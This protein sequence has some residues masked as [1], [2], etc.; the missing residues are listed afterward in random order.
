MS[1]V[2][3]V[4]GCVFFLTDSSI[5]L[6]FSNSSRD[7]S[8]GYVCRICAYFKRLVCVYYIKKDSG[9]VLSA[10]AS[11]DLVYRYACSV[12]PLAFEID[13]QLESIAY[14]TT[15]DKRAS[16]GGNNS[17]LYEVGTNLKVLGAG[18]TF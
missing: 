2:S 14:K 18:A 4:R 1:Y 10:A 9:W 7:T 12:T 3:S 17:N 13:A 16:D 8:P 6:I 11:T 15:E 5:G